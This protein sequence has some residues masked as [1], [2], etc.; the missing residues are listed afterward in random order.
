MTRS[1]PRA[2]VV[3]RDEPQDGPLS[4][5]LRELGFEVLWWPVVRIAPAADPAPLQTALGQA[6]DLDWIVF[7][8]RHAVKPVTVRLPARP[9]RARIAAVGASTAAALRAHGWEPD[10]VPEQASA[11]S[12]ITALAP[13][14]ARGA[15][16]LFP[17]GSRALPVLAAGLRQLGAEVLQVEA[18][19]TDPAQLDAGACRAYIERDAVAAVTFTSPSCVDELAEVLGREH[20]ERLLSGSS[21]IALGP[22]TGRALAERGFKPV[23]AR[24]ATLEG[25]ATTTYRQLRAIEARPLNARP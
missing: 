16:V 4:T 6:A 13:L 8:S 25:L 7:T 9:V 24:P 23:L 5:R 17:A 18:Y 3:T 1:S 21:P 2:V 11:A 19:R 12:L 20:F 14:M 10:V 15:R 22:T